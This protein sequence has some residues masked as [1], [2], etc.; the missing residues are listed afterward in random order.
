MTYF[1]F[2]FFIYNIYIYIHM[3][4]VTFY[5]I[6]YCIFFLNT[7]WCTDK[8]K[9]WHFWIKL[10]LLVPVVLL[11]LTI[12]FIAVS[13]FQVMTKL[14]D[15]QAFSIY[16]TQRQN[17]RNIEDGILSRKFLPRLKKETIKR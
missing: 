4:L 10:I 8:D 1:I 7:R 11:P 2:L 9:T 6:I 5:Q 13:R 12:M 16:E 3:Y 15:L 14:S 17:E